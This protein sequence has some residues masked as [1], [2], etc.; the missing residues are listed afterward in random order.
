MLAGLLLLAIVLT[1]S[2]TPPLR[3]IG[4]YYFDVFDKTEVWVNLEPQ[5]LQP[6]PNPVR[7]NM[8]ASFPGRKIDHAP[9]VIQLR[10]ESIGGVFPYKVREPIFRL[11]FARG[12]L[13]LTD[14]AH[15]FQFVSSCNDC[16]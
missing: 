12:E 13:D 16:N 7:L 14:Q 10:A 11:E 5:G 1:P 4:A 3:E 2:A 15:S 9:A 6:G 8:T